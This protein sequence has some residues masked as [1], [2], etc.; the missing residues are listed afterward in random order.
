MT[1]IYTKHGTGGTNF[2]VDYVLD[3][4]AAGVVA[5]PS[6]LSAPVKVASR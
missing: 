3:Q 5:P 6:F 1:P 4:L 2:L